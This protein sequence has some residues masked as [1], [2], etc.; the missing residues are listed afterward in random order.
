MILAMSCISILG[1]LVWGHPMF[2][3]PLEV[4]RRDYLNL[5]AIMI[6]LPIDTQNWN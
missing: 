2:T 4:E 6:Y 3:V 1:S 5:V